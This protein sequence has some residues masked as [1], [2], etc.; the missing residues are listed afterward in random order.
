MRGLSSPLH[1]SFLPATS[2][3]SAKDQVCLINGLCIV[4]SFVMSRS[5]MEIHNVAHSQR[6]WR[7]PHYHRPYLYSKECSILECS[8]LK[9]YILLLFLD[10]MNTMHG[11]L[12]LNHSAYS[13]SSRLSRLKQ[14]TIFSKQYLHLSCSPNRSSCRCSSSSTNFPSQGIYS[15]RMNRTTA[16]ESRFRKQYSVFSQD[17][18]WSFCESISK[19]VCHD[20]HQRH[21]MR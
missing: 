11:L 13:F 15:S 6:S 2:I 1:V 10:F 19:Q 17:H 3:D 9:I 8:T 18:C 4:R 5:A 14:I 20:L 21:S 12:P 7:L 16:G